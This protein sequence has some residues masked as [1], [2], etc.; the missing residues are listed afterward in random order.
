M[1]RFRRN[2]RLYWDADLQR[3]DSDRPF[4]VFELGRAEVGDLHIKPSAH[5]AISVLGQCD[6]AGRG[7]PLQARGDI[8][9]VAHQVAVALL[10][11]VAQ[12][13][14][15]AKLDAAFGRQSRIALDQA[16]L[17]FDGATHRIDNT[18]KLDEASVA[19]ALDD[20]PM[21]GGDG[22]VDQIAPEAPKAREGT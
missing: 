20:T 11:D 2:L 8:D 21:M 1:L 17:H 15:H 13:N 10:D 9:A 22:G 3:I 14:A 16:V 5:L 7:D 6:R 12:V 4:D 19:G 18:T